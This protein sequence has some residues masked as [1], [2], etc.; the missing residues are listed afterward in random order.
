MTFISILNYLRGRDGPYNE[1]KKIKRFQIFIESKKN[2]KSKSQ[3]GE[4]IAERVKLG[5]QKADHAA[6]RR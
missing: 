1:K 4:S 3:P 6:F 5:R 2:E